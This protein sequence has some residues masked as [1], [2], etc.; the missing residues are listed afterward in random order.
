MA[1]GPDGA[2]IPGV[3]KRAE[4]VRRQGEEPVQTLHQRMEVKDALGRAH[5]QGDVILNVAVPA[6]D[7]ATLTGAVGIGDHT[8]EAILT[9]TT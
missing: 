9:G 1:A 4:E 3:V 8:A 7:A 6:A 2:G 5:P